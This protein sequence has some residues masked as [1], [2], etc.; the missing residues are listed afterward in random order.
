MK[1]TAAREFAIQAHGNQRY[2]EARYA[3]HLDA[4]VAHLRRYGETA[5]VIGYLHDVVEDTDVSYD[6]VREQFGS[7]VADCVS[8][9]TDEPG[10]NRKERKARTYRKMSLVE[11]E[12]ELALVVKA[13]DRLA[14]LQACAADGHER[15][16]RMYADEHAV[17]HAA[18]FRSG[19]C[20]ELWDAMDRLVLA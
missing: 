6:V 10:A 5:Q 20:D 15:R 9:V 19:L 4:V 3:V 16:R 18:A 14:N 11:G 8:I 1:I 12:L 2:G 17:F 7:F 13:A